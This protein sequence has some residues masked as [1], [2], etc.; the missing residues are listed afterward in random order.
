MAI[1]ID[2]SVIP[3][4]VGIVGTGYAARKRAEAIKLDQR[5]QLLVA[6]GNNLQHTQDYCQKYGAAA[7]DT[8]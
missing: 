3:L 4:Q 2:N 1:A 5:V 8:W 7:V 6:T